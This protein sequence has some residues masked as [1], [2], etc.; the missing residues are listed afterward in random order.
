MAILVCSLSRVESM[1]ATR[2]PSR[3]ISLLDPATPFPDAA[4]HGVGHHHRVEMHDITEDA[5]G[6]TAPNVPH[7]RDL[8]RQTPEL[9][10]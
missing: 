1:I 6:W 8:L 10:G 4:K 3:V 5:A 9:R 7:V 2:K